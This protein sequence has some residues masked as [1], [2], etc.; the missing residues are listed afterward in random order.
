M[1]EETERIRAQAD[2]FV[3]VLKRL[4]VVAGRT[5]KDLERMKPEELRQEFI[6]FHKDVRDSRKAYQKSYDD[7]N[8]WGRSLQRAQD[9][10]EGL[11][12]AYRQGK[13]SERQLQRAR[14][15]YNKNLEAFNRA[16]VIDKLTKSLS[17][18]TQQMASGLYEGTKDVLR[19]V[20]SGADALD[21]GGNVISAGVGAAAG[22]I[23]KG[24]SSLGGTM[25]AAGGT[26][27]AAS[28]MTGNA[29]GVLGGAVLALAGGAITAFGDKLG[30]AAKFGVE[31]VKVELQK[32]VK[33]F[34]EASRSGVMFADGMTGLQ[35]A[36]VAATLPVEQMSAALSRNT[37]NF[38]KSGLGMAEAT[39]RM[40]KTL[41]MG[42]DRFRR[43]M[44]NLGYAIEEMPDLIAETMAN[45]SSVGGP[46]K[47][48]N[49][50]VLQ[51]TREYAKHLRVIASITG[52]D[53]KK[54]MEAARAQ[55]NTLLFQQKMAAMEPEARTALTKAMSSMGDTERAAFREMVATGGQIVDQGLAMLAASSPAFAN[56][57]NEMYNAYQ[58]GIA[59]ENKINDIKAK[60]SD[61][62]K[63]DLASQTALGLL[64][65]LGLEGP[66]KSLTEAMT[67]QLI[68]SQKFTK[69]AVESA[70]KGAEAQMKTM[71]ELTKSVHAAQINVQNMALS[72]Q[73]SILEGDVLNKFG[74]AV[75]DVTGFILRAIKKFEKGDTETGGR[76]VTKEQAT[77]EQKRTEAVAVA[78]TETRK[79]AEELHGRDSDIAKQA[80]AEEDRRQSEAARASAALLHATRN[81]ARAQRAEPK[82]VVEPAKTINA[83]PEESKDIPSR[84]NGGLVNM[85]T[86]GGLALL[87]GTEA[88]VP[89]PDGN[90]IPVA[91]DLSPVD[92]LVTN[93]QTGIQNILSSMPTPEPV[94]T[95][96]EVV[97]QTTT[98]PVNNAMSELIGKFDEL[99]TIT[100]QNI[101]A[102]NKI[103]EKIDDSNRIQRDILQV[104]R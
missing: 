32:V 78:A 102:S 18:A 43:E 76:I 53:A 19:G 70:T 13:I 86:T 69:E 92:M 33:G 91:L 25:S 56:Q 27:A 36:A 80:R 50:Q 17:S 88:V 54:R 34:A 39:E 16:G 2:E 12:E 48:T 21:I 57:M 11:E 59:N 81:A 83:T 31:F 24:A 44:M 22:L 79:R 89:L 29:L 71:D 93:V 62:V 61:S 7:L 66:L 94:T 63:K 40:G 9:S 28:L 95:R 30:D 87:H 49:E 97:T 20:Q 103:A 42:G 14:E 84:R 64:Q 6:R 1:A 67:N 51:Q 10:L 38:A 55:A 73:K 8:K 100:R 99:M 98:A 4:G 3:E 47:A 96:T 75:E 90:T 26:I 45:M 82:P 72:I 58:Q 74:K 52:E 60:Y 5:S 35:R 68:E 65:G 104:S 85:P 37:E 46:L 15:Q 23:G 101:L 77:V 41:S